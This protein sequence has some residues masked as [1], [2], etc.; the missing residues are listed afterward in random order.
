MTWT[1][2]LNRKAAKQVEDLRKNVLDLFKFLVKEMEILGPIRG[3]WRNYSALTDRRH[4]CHIKTGRPTYVAVWEV[5]SKK[6]RLIEVIY[7]GTHEGSP[8]QKH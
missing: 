5:K 7:V 6:E 8:Y 1:V 2:K 4:H 3:N